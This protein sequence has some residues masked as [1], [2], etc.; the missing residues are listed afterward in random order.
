MFSNNLLTED[1]VAVKAYTRY[2]VVYIFTNLN[3]QKIAIN[4]LDVG[5]R[6]EKKICLKNAS[7]TPKY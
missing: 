4:A 5:F 1:Q 7:M 6:A 3:D 2:L